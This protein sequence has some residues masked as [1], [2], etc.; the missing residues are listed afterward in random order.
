MSRPIV[1]GWQ[2]VPGTIA[3]F[4]ALEHQL[5]DF[6]TRMKES[7]EIYHHDT[8]RAVLR[9]FGD[10]ENEMGAERTTT[11]ATPTSGTNYTLD[12][13]TPLFVKRSRADVHRHPGPGCRLQ[14]GQLRG[15]PSA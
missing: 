11:V 9:N 8:Q 2:A 12:V 1:G 10:L 3:P 6:R 15:R 5:L 7:N 14:S 13:G 4:G